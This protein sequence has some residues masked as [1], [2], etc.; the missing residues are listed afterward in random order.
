MDSFF[1]GLLEYNHAVNQTLGDILLTHSTQISEKT[2]GLYSH[3]V[4]AH[5]IWNSRVESKQSLLGVW[6]TRPILESVEINKANFEHSTLMLSKTN[7]EEIIYYTNTKGQG[8]SNSIKE[9]FFHIINHSTYHRAQIA[10][11][12]RLCGVEPINT[13]YIFYKR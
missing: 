10:T 13:D 3:I 5:H 4:N 7:L 9:M 2:V 12:L 8:F 1:K 11:E 6:D